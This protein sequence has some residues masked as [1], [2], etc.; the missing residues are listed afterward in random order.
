[1]RWYARLDVQGSTNVEAHMPTCRHLS[2][3]CCEQQCITAGCSY[4]HRCSQ[5]TACTAT[6][7]ELRMTL[8]RVST[9]P[10][11]NRPCFRQP[12]QLTNT[13]GTPTTRPPNQTPNQL[14]NPP[15]AAC[16]PTGG[17]PAPSRPKWGSNTAS[18][19]PGTAAWPWAEWT[20][21]PTR[22][23]THSPPSVCPSAPAFSPLSLT[24]PSLLLPPPLLLPLLLVRLWMVQECLCQPYLWGLMQGLLLRWV[25]AGVG[26]QP[27]GVQLLGLVRCGWLL[28]CFHCLTRPWGAC[29]AADRCT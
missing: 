12:P 21:T 28:G 9:P 10:Q 2:V 24:L 4:Q 16:P 26:S 19:P 14:P 18:Y 15:P 1:M 13:P 29:S 6:Q 5:N 17:A 25:R 8:S 3:Y 20:G 11:P 7:H 27:Q 23:V 22:K